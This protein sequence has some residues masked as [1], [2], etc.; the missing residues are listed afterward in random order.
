V[1]G[2]VSEALLVRLAARAAEPEDVAGVGRVR[3]DLG[4]AE[5]PL[6]LAALPVDVEVVD[7]PDAR[8]GL[9]RRG[10]QPALGRDGEG[11]VDAPQRPEPDVSHLDPPPRC[12]F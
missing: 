12:L 4:A 6:D 9:R 8:R 11:A 10:E 3:V 2:H 1:E 7:E 5:P